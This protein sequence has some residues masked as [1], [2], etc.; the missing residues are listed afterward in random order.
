MVGSVQ[1]LRILDLGTGTG[2]LAAALLDAPGTP[3]ELAALDR[4]PAMLRRAERRLGRRVEPSRLRLEVADVVAVPWDSGSFDLI[5]MGYLL[6]L[7]DPPTAR[8]ALAE[9]RRLLRPG[10]R[11]ISADLC[12]PPGLLGQ[13]YRTAWWV[14]ARVVPGVFG[15]GPGSDVSP[16]LREAGFQIEDDRWVAGVYWTQ[17]VLAVRRGDR[18]AGGI[19]GRAGRP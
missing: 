5:G 10:G 2:A 7:L 13:L 6:H 8:A 16:L 12:V 17:V 1:G 18:T 3:H 14:L 15:P 4:A 9:A 19:S 11:L